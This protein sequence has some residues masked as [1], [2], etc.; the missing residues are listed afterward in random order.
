MAN[1]FD[2]Y[3]IPDDTIKLTEEQKEALHFACLDDSTKLMD[4]LSPVLSENEEIMER[5]LK[6]IERIATHAQEQAIASHN[7]AESASK[8]VKVLTEQLLLAK[9]EAEAANKDAEFSRKVSILSLVVSILAV[10]VSI[11]AIIVPILFG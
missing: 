11:A 5:Q 1:I 6:A 10:L 8:Q 2:S 4:A 9:N 3:Y 7:H